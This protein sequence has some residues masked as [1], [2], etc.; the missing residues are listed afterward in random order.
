M[1]LWQAEPHLYLMFN[2]ST[3]EVSFTLPA[4]PDL[5]HWYLAVDTSLPTPHDLV[6]T[7]AEIAL[8]DPSTYRV[9][10]RSSAILVAYS[11]RTSPAPS[12]GRHT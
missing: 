7:G 11:T 1:I 3:E 12:P 9:G 5:R 8:E 10:P 6:E 2:A 4:L